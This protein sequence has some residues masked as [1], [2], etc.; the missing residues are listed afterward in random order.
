VGGLLL[1]S[2]K[3]L[4]ADPVWGMDRFAPIGLR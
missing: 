2:H 3:L 4:C 1:V